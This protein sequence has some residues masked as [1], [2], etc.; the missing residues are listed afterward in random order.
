MR[1]PNSHDATALIDGA[2]IRTR[3]D[4]LP[5]DAEAWLLDPLP[6]E[7]D[8][9]S[10]SG[11]R[12][13]IER[14]YAPGGCPWDREQTHA[15]LRSYLIEE[16]YEA[17]EA[18][19]RNDLGALREE[20]GDVLMQIFFHA[21]IAQE[22]GTFTLED[23]VEAIA[24][25]MVRRHPH[26]FA[27]VEAGDPSEVWARWEAIKAEERAAAG[28]PTD[29]G[30]LL[31]S[32]PAALP[33]LQRAQS[34]QGRAERVGATP[35]EMVTPLAALAEALRDLGG[36]TNEDSGVR[37]GALLWAAV[38]YARAEGIDAESTLREHAARFIAQVSDGTTPA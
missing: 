26:V 9:R 3:V 27:D 5:A 19:D 31:H 1:Y 28:E 33:A 23:V 35:E 2:P 25:K 17:I 38:S 4:D 21:A 8:L 30:A 15:T 16:S 29:A 10:L 36:A 6:A 14:L 7:Q 13:I 37:L 34:L 12:A 18:I 24:A 20:L 32:L 11:L 22:A